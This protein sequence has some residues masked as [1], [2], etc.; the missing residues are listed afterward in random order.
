[1]ICSAMI[2]AAFCGSTFNWLS[3]ARRRSLTS[4]VWVGEGIGSVP[5]ASP[6]PIWVIFHGMPSASALACL[7]APMLVRMAKN[8]EF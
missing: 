5:P 2:T 6:T 1:M 3:G 4:A 7:A 8:C